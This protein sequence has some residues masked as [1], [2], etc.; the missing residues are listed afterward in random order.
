MARMR[1]RMQVCAYYAYVLNIEIKISFFKFDR[2]LDGFEYIYLKSDSSHFSYI[3]PYNIFNINA[4]EITKL[5][6][7]K[8]FISIIFLELYS[9]N[10]WNIYVCA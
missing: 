6:F 9:I 7:R 3:S 1:R 5:C 10:N 4:T 8:P 2:L